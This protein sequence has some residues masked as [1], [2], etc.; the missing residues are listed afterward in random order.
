MEI[1]QH[2]TREAGV[3]ELE[4]YIAKLCRKTVLAILKEKV[5]S[6]TIDQDKLV[7][8]LGK[9]PFDHTKKLPRPQVGVVTGMAYTQ[10]GGDIL[11]IEVNH[12]DGTGKFIITGQ[13]GDVMKESASIALDYLKANKE[14]YGLDDKAFE[15]QDIHIHV[16]EGATPKDGPSAGVTMTTA[17]VSALAKKS[18][19]REVGMTG[20]VTLRG[21]VL[22][23]GGLKE[24]SISAHRA[25]L[26]VVI[27]PK[28]NEK[29]LDDIPQ[30]VK[31]DITF[32]PVSTI[33]EV[34]QQALR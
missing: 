30:S 9:A 18:V 34:L 1:I 31:E 16:P 27:M 2:Y 22:P 5:E 6:V 3:R 29:D 25:G 10:F 28:D 7:E 13:L 23:I 19:K 26:K 33:D 21:R 32:I 24:K 14:K 15:K 20:E 11:P 12:F 8:F 4:R 17:L